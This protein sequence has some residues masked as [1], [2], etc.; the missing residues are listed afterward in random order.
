MVTGRFASSSTAP[1]TP[2]ETQRPSI[3]ST[4]SNVSIVSRASASTSKLSAAASQ[5]E[6][7][8]PDASD[9]DT[10]PWQDEDESYSAVIT[11]KEHPKEGAGILGLR[12]V[13]RGQR[14]VETP[15]ATPGSTGL[16][17]SG[18]NNSG[19]A[20][21]GVSSR[22][23]SLGTS[24]SKLIRYGIGPSGS[25]DLPTP[26]PSAWARAELEIS[27]QPAQG[28]FKAVPGRLS[29]S[30][31]GYGE[32]RLSEIM[33]QVEQHAA[34]ARESVGE[35]TS[36]LT[37][38]SSADS[39][40]GRMTLKSAPSKLAKTPSAVEEAD[41]ERS[42][43][44]S[45][46]TLGVSGLPGVVAEHGRTSESESATNGL[47]SKESTGAT[48]G[49]P[50]PPKD[51]VSIDMAH[52]LPQTPVPKSRVLVAGT[53]DST[54]PGSSGV[55]TS[56]STTG[57]ITSTVASAIRYVIGAPGPSPPPKQHLGLL[58]M[59]PGQSQQGALY[60]P[61]DDRPHLK[62]DFTLGT[63]PFLFR[64]EMN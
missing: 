18:S 10:N 46:V 1:S 19:M 42:L 25:Q 34:D 55:G 43:T 32:E 51:D 12:D 53:H 31:S 62:Y 14:S 64:A 59:N 4:P 2:M 47:H 22:F 21:A 15:P 54:G 57:S 28:E 3:A 36:S 39:Q 52:N 23:R 50:V 20:T 17:T 33:A 49:P 9:E 63:T 5:R 44:N 40:L 29:E 7:T 35:T 26:P 38:S 30:S 58:A 60:P 56:A 61:I 45:T 24:A 48:I 37:S 16:S 6:A 41:E 8:D 13:L 11:R 27:L